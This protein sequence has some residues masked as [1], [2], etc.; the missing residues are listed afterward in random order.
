MA[1]AGSRHRSTATPLAFAYLALVVYASLYPFAGWQRPPA[2]GWA[3]MLLLP[4]PPWR[5]PYDVWFNV[6]G[7]LPLGLLI[8]LAVRRSGGG[9]LAALALTV[10][11]AAAVSYAAEVAQSALPGR[12]PSLKDWV[13]NVGGAAGGALAA[14]ALHG[15]GAVGHWSGMRDRWFVRRSAGALALLALWPAGL[16]FPAPVPLALG[17]VGGALRDA[18]V[19]ALDGVPWAAQVHA[20]L[21]R[22]A[23]EA[24]LATAPVRPGAELAMT[25]LGLLGPCLVAYSVMP[26]GARRVVLALGAAMLAVAGMTLSTLLNF[27]PSQALAWWT[28]LAGPS[29]A[30]GVLTAALLAPLP[31]RL[32]AGLGLAVLAALAALVAQ[33]PADPYFAQSLQD[34]EQGRFVRFHGLAQWLGWLWPY[35]AMAWLLARLGRRD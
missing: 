15:A 34:W 4:W 1:A 23:A 24:A 33:A 31:M 19:A 5:A 16:L 30:V 28:P 27:G 25:A 17:Q 20:A 26:P 35:A 8:A 11:A 18:A 2:L 3:E 9:A 29:L 14:L 21:L 7:Y 32:C 13:A 22:D 12:H 6:L 10:L